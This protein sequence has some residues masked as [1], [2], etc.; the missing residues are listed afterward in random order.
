MKKAIIFAIAATL[1]ATA[2]PAMA[3]ESDLDAL[4]GTYTAL[5]PEFVKEENRD[6]WFTCIGAYETDPE[7]QELYYTM[8][9]E[10]YMGT[11]TGQEAI[12]AYTPENS[13]F[14]C[15]FENDLEKLTI[16][17]DTIS[18]VDAE[19]NELCSH[20]Y[21]Y[22]GDIDGVYADQTYEGWF[23]LF[24]TE[25]EDAG[26]FTYFAFTGDTPAGEWH[27]E[28]RYGDNLD[29]LGLFIEGEYAYWMPSGILADYDE[30]T[31]QSCIKLF[32][33]ENVGGG[34]AAEEEGA[35]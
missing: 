29:D 8:L 25:D 34:E 1:A 13:A 11:L 10:G 3:E 23:K 31:I 15:Y 30:D 33:D 20:T 26:I 7:V 9:T 2:V 16:D 17:G 35:A 19:G 18:G 5:F 12:D 28:Y 22:V 21:V 4:Q 6:W 14:D 27:I 24:K 32:V